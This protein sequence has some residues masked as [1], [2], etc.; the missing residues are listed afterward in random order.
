MIVILSKYK[1][2]FD[3]LNREDE[4]VLEYKNLIIEIKNKIKNADTLIW[5]KKLK[6]IN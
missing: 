2:Y 3:K 4:L 1:K 5:S 6:K